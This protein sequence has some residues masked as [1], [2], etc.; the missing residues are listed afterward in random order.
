MKI[1]K[2]FSYE[3]DYDVKYNRM[4]SVKGSNKFPFILTF[5]DR[6]DR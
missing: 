1:T 6:T 3:I 5:E 2:M 4:E